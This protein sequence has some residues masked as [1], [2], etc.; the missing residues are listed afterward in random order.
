MIHVSR[1]LLTPFFRKDI[2]MHQAVVPFAGVSN[3]V[4]STNIKGVLYR[5]RQAPVKTTWVYT[6]QNMQPLPAAS[7]DVRELLLPST[8]SH[9]IR[10]NLIYSHDGRILQDQICSSSPTRPACN[11]FLRHWQY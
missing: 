8:L 6:S 1:I 3:N 10:E 11:P 9:E 2:T 5:A 4:T 7:K